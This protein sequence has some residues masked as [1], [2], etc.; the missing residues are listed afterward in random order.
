MVASLT[1][2]WQTNDLRD[3]RT[4][5]DEV[6]AK[7]IA[8]GGVPSVP[9]SPL[10]VQDMEAAVKKLA[11]PPKYDAAVADASR[12]L[13]RT[14]ARYATLRLEIEAAQVRL[15][16]LLNTDVHRILNDIS[17][18]MLQPNPQVQQMVDGLFGEQP[19]Y[20]FGEIPGRIY[21][22]E[23][24]SASKYAA[25]TRLVLEKVQELDNVRSRISSVFHVENMPAE[26]RCMALVVAVADRLDGIAAR[27]ERVEQ[28]V[29][30][31]EQ[32]IRAR[33]KRR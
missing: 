13:S 25:A 12:E 28:Q 10:A 1:R 24:S 26:E 8:L 15:H 2:S 19:R 3:L 22:P 4:R 33:S 16:H 18:E 29:R 5:Y 6:A 17:A 14:I 27:I 30:Q 20:P 7:I 32:P 11:V 23:F 9:I 31:F 21:E